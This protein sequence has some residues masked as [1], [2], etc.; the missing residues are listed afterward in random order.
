M[1][2]W[3]LTRELKPSNGKKTAFLTNGAGTTVGFHVEEW[4]LIHSY[5]L[6]VRSPVTLIWRLEDPYLDL[7]LEILSHSG[8]GFQKIESPSLRNTP[9]IW[10]TPFI[11]D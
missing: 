10:A 6:I 4:E 3:S 5:L 8:Y 2:T 9:L 7:G 1:V 11:W